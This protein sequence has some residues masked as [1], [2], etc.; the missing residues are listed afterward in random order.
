LLEL[1]PKAREILERLST[2]HRDEI[3]RMR[4]ML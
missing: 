2:V 3:V 1:T 4:P